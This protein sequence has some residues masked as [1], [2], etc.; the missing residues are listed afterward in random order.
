MSLLQAD[1][2]AV[3]IETTS[4]SSLEIKNSIEFER[5]NGMVV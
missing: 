1:N 4:R 3:P 5:G 2:D